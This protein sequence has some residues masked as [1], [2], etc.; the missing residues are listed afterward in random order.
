MAGNANTPGVSVATKVAAILLVFN[1][2][3]EHSVAQIATRTDLAV[4]TTHRLVTDMTSRRLLECTA[5][6]TYRAGPLVR[7]AGHP[8]PTTP[9]IEELGPFVVA[10]LAEATGLRARLGMLSGL[11]ISYVEKDPG[12]DPVSRFRKGTRLP[13][14]ATALGK[15]LLAFAPPQV[16]ETLIMQG[17]FP[18]TSHTLTSPQVFRRA[19][20]GIRACGGIATS[21]NELET[22]V[23]SL[24]VP[25]RD[26]SEHVVAAL[27]L[28]GADSRDDLGRLVT[29]LTFAASCLSREL[30]YRSTDA[31]SANRARTRHPVRRS[32]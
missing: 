31:G 4:S 16:V 7:L 2:G 19:L 1:E 8:V 26:R 5:T 6:G 27:E 9:A 23:T 28:T 24:A 18:Y 21:R 13:A 3:A 11:R 14:H 30:G 32:R 25:I 12:P 20:A 17:L 15:V 22:G 10:D 29:V